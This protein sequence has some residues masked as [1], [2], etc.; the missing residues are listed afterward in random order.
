[1]KR[2]IPVLFMCIAL[3]LVGC[4]SGIRDV[5]LDNRRDSV[6]IER[7]V[8]FPIPPD[9]ARIRAL[10]E[11]DENGNVV[12]RWLD[13]ANTKNVELMFKLDSLGNVI[14]DMRVQRDTLYLPGKEIYVD[15]E[16]KV[17]YPVEKKLTRWQQLKM[18]LGGIA[19][20]ILAVIGT[21][22]LSYVVRWLIRRKK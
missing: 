9:S 5:V 21:F 12:L 15:G 22:G 10:M 14:A 17:P 18:D 1:M 8:P 20:G 19:F 13:M 7:L 6:Y 4:R 3:W 2:G 16:T 11:C